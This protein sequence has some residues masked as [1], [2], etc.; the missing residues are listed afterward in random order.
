MAI[1]TAAKKNKKTKNEIAAAFELIGPEPAAPLKPVLTCTEPTF[2][3]L[4]RVFAEG[5]PSLAIVTTEGGSFIGGYGMS[6]DH[7][8]RTI[9]GL[10]QLWDGQPI[11][12]VRAIDGTSILPGRRLACHLMV[13]PQVADQL[14]NDL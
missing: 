11:R 2:E 10:S 7:K 5:H 8:L 4:C 1:G 13:Q 6:E 9:S 3:G 12:R 14:L